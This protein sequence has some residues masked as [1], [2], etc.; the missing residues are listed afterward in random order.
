MLADAFGLL[1]DNLYVHL[2][3]ADSLAQQNDE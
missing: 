1:G 2:D 3:E